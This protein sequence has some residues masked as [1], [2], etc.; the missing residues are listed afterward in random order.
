MKPLK[1]SSQHIFISLLLKCVL[2]VGFLF[3]DCS[4]EALC[5]S[6][7]D[8]CYM[9]TFD[10]LLLTCYSY[11]CLFNF[12]SEVNV[13]YNCISNKFNNALYEQLHTI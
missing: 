4:C 10:L 9:N 2:I 6:Y 3:V 5:Y 13:P 7:Q 1:S 11:F 8:R 12:S